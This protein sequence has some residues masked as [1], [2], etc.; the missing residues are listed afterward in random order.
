[1]YIDEVGNHDLEV[2]TRD[3]NHRYLSLTGVIFDL[4]YVRSTVVPRLDALKWTHFASHPD[5]PVVLHRHELVNGKSPF[6]SL[7]EPGRSAAFNTD[8]LVLIEELDYTV[9][10]VVIDKLEHL[11]R[12]RQWSAHPYH[13]CL[14]VLV[15]RF[16]LEL[17]RLGEV[18]DVMA[19]SRGRREDLALKDAYRG[20]YETGSENVSRAVVQRRLTSKELKLSQKRDNVAGLQI[21]DLLAHPSWRACLARHEGQ[22]LATNF[23]GLVAEI[24]ERSKY[25]RRGARIDGYGRK[26]LP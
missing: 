9:V 8:L 23:G 12:Y 20:I 4:E 6:E 25:R 14:L 19:E 2:A 10:T 5:A 26:W 1:M 17:G 3:P 18:G 22:P 13:Y 24:L 11:T 15:E 7:R 16:V 21:A